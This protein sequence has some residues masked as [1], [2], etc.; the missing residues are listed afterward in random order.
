MPKEIATLAN[1]I[2]TD[3][4]TVSVTPVSS[5]AQAIEQSVYFVD[6]QNKGRLLVDLLG[7]SEI[8]SALVFTRTK[9]S[10]DRI[11]KKLNKANLPAGSIHGDKSQGARQRALSEFKTGKTLVLV[12]TDIAARGID[13]DQLSHVINYDLPNEPETYVHRIG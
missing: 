1:T 3:P 4:I 11:C 13:I 8:T 2:L 10:A 12:A 9:H 6:N 7:N 5:S